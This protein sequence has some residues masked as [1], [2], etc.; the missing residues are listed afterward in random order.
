MRRPVQTNAD[1]R[2]TVYAHM[3]LELEMVDVHRVR[4]LRNGPRLQNP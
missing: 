1:A 4:R 2:P 3:A